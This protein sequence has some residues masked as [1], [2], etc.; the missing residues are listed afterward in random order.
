VNETRSVEQ[1]T[2]LLEAAE[3]QNQLL[4]KQ[5]QQLK[6]KVAKYRQA[7]RACVSACA[8]AML[9]LLLLLP[10]LLRR[11]RLLPLLM[12]LPPLLLPP[13]MLR[14]LLLLLLMLMRPRPHP[15]STALGDLVFLWI[16]T[17]RPATAAPHPLSL[18]FGCRG[19]SP[20]R[21]RPTLT[22]HG[23]PSCAL[24]PLGAIFCVCRSGTLRPVC[25]TRSRRR[26]TLSA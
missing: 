22:H 4:L 17:C 21:L 26:T 13:L 2:K 1:L 25:Q 6:A 10:L 11:R 20:S 24:S 9:Q 18:R 16:A 19:V 8:A 15:H 5:V 7:V 23:L 12:L 14:L 3:E